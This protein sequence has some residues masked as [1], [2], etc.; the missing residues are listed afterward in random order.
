MFDLTS[1][2]LKRFASR[3]E[4]LAQ[5]YQLLAGLSPLDRESVV[6]EAYKDLDKLRAHFQG[7]DTQRKLRGIHRLNWATC[8]GFPDVNLSNYIVDYDIEYG[9][10]SLDWGYDAIIRWL[11]YEAQKFQAWQKF[12]PSCSDFE[13]LRRRVTDFQVSKTKT[14][15][16]YF[17]HVY[18][19]VQRFCFAEQGDFFK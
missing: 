17:T 14:E 11:D 10:F 3:S 13:H 7:E 4:E 9:M 8:L 19:V 18:P 5:Y 6:Q 1:T 2:L 12:F 16:E 15:A